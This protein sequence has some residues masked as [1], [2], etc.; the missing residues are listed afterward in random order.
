MFPNIEAKPSVKNPKAISAKNITKNHP[1]TRSYNKIKH[2]SNNYS[3]RNCNL[4]AYK[5]KKPNSLK[6]N[7]KTINN[8]TYDEST[9]NSN[10]YENLYYYPPHNK[11][12]S[13][14]NNLS[15]EVCLLYSDFN[16]NK[17]PSLRQNIS[18]IR[19]MIKNRKKNKDKYVNNIFYSSIIG[20]KASL[21]N[22]DENYESRKKEIDSLSN[23]LY[24]KKNKPV[25]NN[26]CIEFK[27]NNFKEE[28]LNHKNV[29]TNSNKNTIINAYRI[30]NSGSL[31]TTTYK[32]IHTNKLHDMSKDKEN[33][34]DNIKYNLK[35]CKE[36]SD[37]KKILY[38]NTIQEISSLPNISNQK[39]IINKKI[40]S[41]CSIIKSNKDS[42]LTDLN[43][44]QM[45]FKL[46][47]FIYESKGG[48]KK[49]NEFEKNIY[50]MKIFQGFQK[51]KLN[52]LF[53][54][55]IYNVQNYINHIEKNFNKYS[56]ISKEYNN[57]YQE[58]LRYLHAVISDMDNELKNIINNHIQLEYDVDNLITKNIKKQKELE[59][60]ID[61]RNF[62]YRVKHKDEKISKSDVYYTFYIES[63]RFTLANFFSKLFQ[64]G[65]NNTVN[66]YLNNLPQYSE[67][68]DKTEESKYIVRN[69]PPLLSDKNKFF[70]DN[71]NKNRNKKKRYNKEA[72]IEQMVEYLKKNIFSEPE[73]IIQIFTFLEDQNRFLLKQN[74]NKRLIIEKHID[75]L[76]KCIPQ[77]DI[78]IEKRV[79]S[80][81]IVKQK[82][83]SIIKQRNQKLKQKYNYFYNINLKND[84]FEK[85]KKKQKKRE[86][87]K[88]SFTDLQYFQT[89]HYNSQI[90]KEKYP[91]MV[92]F[93][94]L[95]KSFLTFL[96][97]NYDG[98][99]KEN[100]YTHISRDHL[101]EILEY[102]ENMD[103]NERN[104]YFIYQY[105]IKI[106]KLYEYICD[107]VF[108]KN[109]EYN[110]NEKNKPII[111]KETDKIGEKRKLDNARTIRILIENKRI[112]GNKQLIEKWL[113]PEKYIS[114][115]VD[116]NNYKLL[117]KNKSQDDI[118]KKRFLRKYKKKGINEEFMGFAHY[119]EE[120]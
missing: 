18:N 45:D 22:N 39:K 107:Y 47:D 75:E 93:R 114:R 110:L 81:I 90:K 31:S 99:T 119:N 23:N 88:S 112:E 16:F 10:F 63:K 21:T 86:A 100:F 20:N 58:Y 44:E 111:K 97:M 55:E 7:S 98:L 108:K 80:E 57:N 29:I 43:T 82:E 105:S 36:K 32:T 40:P 28:S 71:R 77:E 96:S 115:K 66:K 24:S 102:S 61:I 38:S 13:Y 53:D 106:L 34:K 76:E 85:E 70:I 12:Y 92:L 103:F 51:N 48:I 62:L 2:I 73:E 120:E 74:D 60:L 79:I 15:S 59:N 109:A 67:D 26:S 95:I 11:K 87:G 64:N 46:N 65:S 54:Q 42:F 113:K 30:T 5:N 4:E 72:E 33:T 56:N 9:N 83:L 118:L 50:Q 89:L 117:L 116:N 8:P 91:G 94:K 35:S 37:R 104:Y 25:R 101:N 1:I 27:K 6:K 49:I 17:A 68:I 3:S 69:N 52:Y 78:D 41:I 84:I 14:I 19:N